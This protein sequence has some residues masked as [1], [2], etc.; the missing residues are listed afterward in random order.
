[1]KKRGYIVH[2]FGSRKSK[3]YGVFADFIIN[4]ITVTRISL[5]ISLFLSLSI[6][7]RK[8]TWQNRQPEHWEE[9]GLLFYNN[10]L[11][12]LTQGTLR[13]TSLPFEGTLPMT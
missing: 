9:T 3:Q 7:G 13:T 12:E 11:G 1:M 6:M 2:D 4:H 8:I 5:S 10:C